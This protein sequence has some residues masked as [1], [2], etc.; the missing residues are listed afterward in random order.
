MVLNAVVRIAWYS[1]LFFILAY[2]RSTKQ[3]NVLWI[4][5]SL[6]VTLIQIELSS[7]SLDSVEGVSC[8]PVAAR[9][10]TMQL[11]ILSLMLK[12]EN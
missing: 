12:C 11:H 7:S 9:S 4:C 8:E 10:Q 6:P 5:L 2:N 1:E 3:R